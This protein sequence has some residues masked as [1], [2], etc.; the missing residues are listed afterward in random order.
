[1][2]EEKARTHKNKLH[3]QDLIS[4]VQK[5]RTITSKTNWANTKLQILEQPKNEKHRS[6]HIHAP[7]S[8]IVTE[9]DERCCRVAFAASLWDFLSF[10]HIRDEKSEYVSFCCFDFDVRFPRRSSRHLSTFLRMSQDRSRLQSCSSAWIFDA[11][12]C[13]HAACSYWL[14]NTS[15]VGQTWSLFC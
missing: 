1:M 10:A 11:C 4:Q 7:N 14:H 5:L 12:S 2:S 3:R 13:V 6:F 8:Q 9:S 15:C